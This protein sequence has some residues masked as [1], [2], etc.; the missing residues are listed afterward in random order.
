MII[1][2]TTAMNSSTPFDASYFDTGIYRINTRCEKW[3]GHRPEDGD[4]VLPMW[5]ADMDFP[6][7]PACQEALLRRGAHGTYGYTE[8]LED[9]SQA[10]IDFWQ[11][12]HGLKLEK[13][14]ITTLPCVVTGLKLAIHAFTK[15]G[16][17]VIIQS[18]VYGPFRRSVEATGRKVADSPLKR[19]EQGLYHM[20]WESLE[21]HLRQ[22]ARLMLLCSPHN[23]VSRLWSREELKQLMQLLSRYGAKLAADE[24]HADFTYAPGTFVPM[25]SLQEEGVVSFCA[26]SKTFNLAG[27]QQA[28]VLCKDPEMTAALRSCIDSFGIVSGNMFA[29]EATRAAYTKGDAWLDGLLNYLTLCRQ[30]VKELMAHHLPQVTVSPV[31][32]T[33]CAWFDLRTFGLSEEEL[34]A[35]MIRSGVRLTAGSFFGQEEGTGFFRMIFATPR[36]NIEQGIQRLARALKGT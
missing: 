14:H 15:P 1:K 18:P 4:H 20:D 27:L 30:D 35:R 26:A 25:L 33:Y 16:D 11:R 2:E 24:I 29:L 13:G 36:R 28:T 32:A 3:D 8:V 17:S 12:R 5:V 10:L 6:S 21:N 22:G 34:L 9:D 23:P 7:P 19:D 31:E